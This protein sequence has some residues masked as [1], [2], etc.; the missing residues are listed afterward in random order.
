MPKNI[1]LL[2]LINIKCKVIKSLSILKGQNLST[3]NIYDYG[4]ARR[5][6]AP[7]LT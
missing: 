1:T 6:N 7:F 3:M 2:R 5:S 4:E